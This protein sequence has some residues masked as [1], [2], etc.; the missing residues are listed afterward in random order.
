MPQVSEITLKY[1]AKGA[2]AAERAD[3]KV[4][5]SVQETAKTAQKEAS[6]IS[7]WMQ[8]HKAALA[9]IGAVTAG[10]ML[11]LIR[12]S[13]QLSAQL[14]SIRLG[15][16]M[17][18][19]VI[20]ADLAPA[21]AGLS[22]KAIDLAKAY[23]DLDPAIRKPLS[24]LIG[25][26]TI[27]G[28]LL[29]VFAV[30]ETIIAG[31]MVGSFLAWLAALIPTAGILSALGTVVGIV[32]GAVAGLAAILGISVGAAAALIVAIVALIAIIV[33]YIF[34]IGGARDAINAWLADIGDFV[35][36]A[37]QRFRKF[38]SKVFG[39]IKKWVRNM[40]E[41]FGQLVSAGKEKAKELRT[42]IENRIKRLVEDAKQWGTDLV[43]RFA[44]GVTSRLNH[45]RREADRLMGQIKDALSFDIRSNDRMAER[46]GRDM[47]GHFAKGVR[48]N[49]SRIERALPSGQGM[50][51]N[52]SK[53]VKRNR[54]RI[55][56][57]L[58]SERGMAG[59]FAKAMRESRSRLERAL[60]SAT[61]GGLGSPMAAPAPGGGDTNVTV[62]MERGAVT[63]QGTGSR[64]VDTD[65]MAEQ[66]GDD[67]ASRFNR[68]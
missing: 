27:G 40:K 59:H 38:A 62:I 34:N 63:M 14:A 31:T 37:I 48:R 23:Q 13:P 32:T 46:W 29:G 28:I 56:R 24:A 35:K 26:V 5:S 55:E 10:I 53:A 67:L 36:R 47:V 57:A 33:A 4:R 61:S 3:K 1:A 6:T 49:R 8:R 66:V 17:L 65:R 15:F 12:M 20:G 45:L 18:A 68:R 30:L 22:S 64:G 44:S 2:K 11:A 9:A 19:M 39:R 16:S 54:S 42:A 41:R 25:I 21:T 51:G 58:P 7:Q 43:N 60:P 52:I 50:V